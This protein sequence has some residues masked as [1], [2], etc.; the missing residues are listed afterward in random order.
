MDNDTL[1][2]MHFII[3]LKAVTS[4]QLVTCIQLQL[5]FSTVLST[6][7]GE[8]IGVFPFFIVFANNYIKGMPLAFQLLK[9]IVTGGRAAH[10]QCK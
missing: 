2:F 4:S 1:L 8:A 10:H 5:R 3:V 7:S 6:L 9:Y